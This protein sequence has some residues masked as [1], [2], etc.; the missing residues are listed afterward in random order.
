MSKLDPEHADAIIDSL[1]RAGLQG[2]PTRLVYA[3][4]FATHPEME[5]LFIR[6][7]NGS[8][9]ANMLSEAIR[10]LLDYVGENTYGGNLLRIEVVNH[11]QLGVPA[12]VFPAFF[13]ARREAFRAML[14]EEWRPDHGQAWDALLSQIETNLAA[15]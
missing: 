3:H 7:R 12:A 11:E 8:V 6:D 14:G 15:P 10:A 5:A 1:E 9:R 4:L 2:D 13:I